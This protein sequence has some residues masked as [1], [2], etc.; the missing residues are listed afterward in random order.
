MAQDDRTP[1]LVGVAQVEQ[2]EAELSAA[3]EPLELM[4]QALDAAAADC[5]NPKI[6]G[7]VDSVRVVCGMWGYSNPARLVA[8]RIGAGSA[9]TGLTSL[10]GNYVQALTN[11][12]FLDIQSGRNEVI[13]ITG[14]ECGRTQARAR[15]AGVELDWNPAATAPGAN[16]TARQNGDAPDFFL[17]SNKITR[18]PAEL[19]R[20]IERPIQFYPIFETAL[21]HAN[22]ESVQGHLERISELWAG[23]NRV[24]RDNPHAWIRKPLSASEIRTLRPRTGRFHT[25]IPN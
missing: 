8:Q 2:R 24:A 9:E 16:P 14:A 6:L 11:R 19:A 25:P 10:G 13:V 3:K 17:G 5:G 18:H 15:K 21:R 22:R 1:I 23:F 12:S 7:A 4:V 20:G